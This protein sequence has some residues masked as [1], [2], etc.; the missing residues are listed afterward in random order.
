M[1]ICNLF[2]DL[3]K[4]TGNFLMFSQ[5][6]EDL[7]KYA[8]EQEAYK[9]MPSKFIAMDVNYSTVRENIE[10]NKW[11]TTANGLNGDIPRYLQ[12]YFDN[13]CA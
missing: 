3:T 4:N 2:S 10:E 6:T 7:T 8:V 12:H 5:Y 9:V 11:N 1:A 13:S